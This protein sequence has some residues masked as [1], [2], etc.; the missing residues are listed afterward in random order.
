MKEE[1][2]FRQVLAKNY[3]QSNYRDRPIQVFDRAFSAIDSS[4]SRVIMKNLLEYWKNKIVLMIDENDYFAN[5]FE[6]VLVLQDGKLID[7]A[8][9][10]ILS[11]W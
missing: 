8:N 9:N 1:L 11:K 5:F 10:D 2:R 4:T 7:C 6:K 3:F